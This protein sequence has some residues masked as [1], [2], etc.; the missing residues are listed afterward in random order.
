LEQPSWKIADLSDQAILA[1]A[2]QASESLIA[3]YPGALREHDPSWIAVTTEAGTYTSLALLCGNA[4]SITAFGAIVIQPSTVPFTL[5]EVTFGNYNVEQL[6][7]YGEPLISP[8]IEES[9]K[10]QLFLDLFD[11]LKKQLTPRQVILLLCVPCQGPLYKILTSTS[12]LKDHYHVLQYAADYKRRLIALPQTFDEY[13]KQLGSRTRSDLNRN[14]RKLKEHVNNALLVK[15]YTDTL[16]VTEFLASAEVISKKTY[17]WNL[18]GRGLRDL[19][20]FRSQLTSAAGR[21]WLRCYVLYCREQPVAFMVGYLHRGRYYSTDIGYDPEWTSWSVGNVL[22]CEVVRDLIEKASSAKLFDFMGDRPTHDR[23]SNNVFEEE[24]AF[25]LFPK[26][27]GS[28]A[29]YL[30]LRLTDKLSILLSHILET[31][32]LKTRIRKLVRQIS[33]T[34]GSG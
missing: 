14:F 2:M 28:T 23:L 24:A 22:H 7:M 32:H 21:G 19:E 20:R 26:S 10:R 17:Q 3:A 15:C 18:L 30:S 29:L 34:R 1:D 5:G 33:T 31:L 25:Y 12:R 9:Q 16:G 27:L 11:L 4:A 8:G 6:T 13:L